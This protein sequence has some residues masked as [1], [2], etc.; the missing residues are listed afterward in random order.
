MPPS[1]NNAFAYMFDY[2]EC[3]T[4][5]E[6]R[7]VIKAGTGLTYCVKT[8]TFYKLHER[9][10][11]SR[12][13]PSEGIVTFNM[14]KLDGTALDFGGEIKSNHF[15]CAEGIR[16]ML[17]ACT[18][19]QTIEVYNVYV[20]NCVITFYNGTVIEVKEKLDLP[21]VIKVPRGVSLSSCST[22]QQKDLDFLFCLEKAMK[23]ESMSYCSEDPV[24]LEKAKELNSSC[25]A[26]Y[27]R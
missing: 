5:P 22:D 17:D 7:T 21:P 23:Y 20:Y 4:N 1:P 12:E 16:K 19:N 2:L 27:K 8:S 26:D 11:A 25:L 18:S 3:D 9:G 10:W 15:H 13:R 6:K 14:T 24:C